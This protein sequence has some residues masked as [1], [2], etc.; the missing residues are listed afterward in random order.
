M[1]GFDPSP[2]WRAASGASGWILASVVGGITSIAI[3]IFTGVCFAAEPTLYVQGLICL[4]PRTQRNRIAT[5]IDD[6]GNTLRAWLFARLVSMFAVGLFVTI[7]LSIMH[8]P[9]AGTLGVIAGILSFIPN[10]GSIASSI[11]AIVLAMVIDLKSAL[12]VALIFWLAHFIDD[13]LVLPIAERRIVSLPPALTATFQLL[14]AGPAGIVG[15]MLA[16]PLT[17]TAIVLT[18]RLWVEGDAD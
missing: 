4:F 15:V 1:R 11:P 17:A 2:L 3:V 18:R 13:F 10:I 9:F 5:V 16:A 12:L 7:G 8:I 14:L 6:V